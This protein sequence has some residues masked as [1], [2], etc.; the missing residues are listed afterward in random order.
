[1]PGLLQR[2][3]AQLHAAPLFAAREDRDL[4]LGVGGDAALELPP[5]L[6]V[7]ADHRDRFAVRFDHRCRQQVGVAL[8]DELQDRLGTLDVRLADE[9]RRGDRYGF[10]ERRAALA[11]RR[12]V[13]GNVAE[14]HG[15]QHH[16]GEQ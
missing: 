1:M 5:G 2:L 15:Q 12:V 8:D 6:E 4:D 13:I 7:I 16:A 11:N 9:R 3:E 10:G 14:V